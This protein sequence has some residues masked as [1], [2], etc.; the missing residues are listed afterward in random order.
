MPGYPLAGCPGSV[1]LCHGKLGLWPNPLTE[2]TYPVDPIGIVHSPFRE[3]FAIPRQPRLVAVETEIEILPPYDRDEAL[4]GLEAFSHVWIVFLFH[5][6]MDKGW[7]PTV[8]PPRL[9]GNKRLG[10]FATRSTF[11]PNAIG[12]SAVELAG[13]GREKGKLMVR[14]RGADLLDGTPVLDIKPYIPYSDAIPEAKG[15]FAPEPPERALEVHFSPDADRAL[16]AVEKDYPEF[17]A[18][19]RELLSYDPRPAYRAGEAGPRTYGVHLYDFDVRWRVEE[20]RVLVVE[21]R[22]RKLEVKS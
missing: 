12:L 8:R 22:R 17:R 2:M 15:G 11:R 9:G 4:T 6:C 5:E 21:V 10:V 19:I 1:Y 14:V 13:F 16:T 18:L 3:K 7:R 20:G